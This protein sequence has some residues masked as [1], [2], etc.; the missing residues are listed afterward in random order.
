MLFILEHLFVQLLSAHATQGIVSVAVFIQK[1]TP[2][3][4][5]I[6]F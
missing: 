6:Y 2:L 1:I 3:Y 5:A 4:D